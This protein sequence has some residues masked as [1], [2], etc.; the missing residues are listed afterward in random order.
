MKEGRGKKGGEGNDGE[1]IAP[2]D[3]SMTYAQPYVFATVFHN[4]S[5]RSISCLHNSNSAAPHLL[6]LLPPSLS[7]GVTESGGQSGL[8]REFNRQRE[9][10]EKSVE[11]LKRKLA[12]D[13]EM[14]RSDNARLMREN[15]QLTK[16]INELRREIFLFKRQRK[17]R[18]AMAAGVSLGGVGIPRPPRGQSGKQGR[19]EGMLN[20]HPQR[21]I[22]LQM[23]EIERLRERL[24]ELE[25]GSS[26]AVASGVASS[27][28]HK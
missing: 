13:M 14:H 5:D 27:S 16:E 15:V 18:S 3:I 10:L 17:V 7:K 6:P 28:R 21:E 25:D 1:A 26:S 2:H 19:H 11:S 23:T 24:T 8:Q 12:K 20:D 4:P 22:E 9:Y